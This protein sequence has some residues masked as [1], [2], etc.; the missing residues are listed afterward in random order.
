MS[1]SDKKHITDAYE[2]DGYVYLPHFMSVAEIAELND[3]LTRYVAEV[4][5][6]MPANHVFYEDAADASTL[7]QLQDMHRHDAYFGALLMDSRL[8]ELAEILLD[9]EVVP[10]NVEF[11]NKPARIGKPTPPHQDNFYFNLDPAEAVTMWLAL[12]EADEQNGCVRYVTGSHR[13]G[14]RS[15]GRTGTLGFS[16]GITD[17]SSPDDQANGV[18]FPAQAGD[19]LVHHAMTVHWAEGNT[20][21]SRSR[22]AIGLIYFARSAQDNK[23]TR[24]AY[25]QALQGAETR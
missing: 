17:F 3:H 10:K 15:H 18:A 11:F 1:Q 9:D 23:T 25:Q 22:R 19:L 13:R 4:V 12:E 21:E 7:K 16:Q 24:E 2:R 20:S 6:V 14:L 5:P 8:R